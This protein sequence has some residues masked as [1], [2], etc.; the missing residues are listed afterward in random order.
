[1]KKT[2]Q[3]QFSVKFC[4]FQIMNGKRA[5][6]VEVGETTTAEVKTYIDFSANYIV[7]KTSK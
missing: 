5:T 6:S 4:E 2:Y 1:M 3:E 7:L